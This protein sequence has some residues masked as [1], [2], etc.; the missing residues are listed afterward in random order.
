MIDFV[1]DMIVNDMIVNDLAW[2][3]E[4]FSP[5]QAKNSK[6]IHSSCVASTFLPIKKRGQIV[7]FT[8]IN[9]FDT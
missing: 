7:D 2:C 6:I 9:I 8:T 3:C 1:I 4:G 5:H